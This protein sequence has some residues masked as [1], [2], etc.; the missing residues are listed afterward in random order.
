[1][2]YDKRHDLSTQS[3]PKPQPNKDAVLRSA[4]VQPYPQAELKQFCKREL[5]R[6]NLQLQEEVI[7]AKGGSTLK[8]CFTYSL[9]HGFACL[10][11]GFNTDTRGHLYFYFISLKYC[12]CI[13]C[14]FDN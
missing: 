9:H 3:A 12:F 6:S 8:H 5:C 11:E 7:T 2:K 14:R 4:S 1:M 10:I 13:N